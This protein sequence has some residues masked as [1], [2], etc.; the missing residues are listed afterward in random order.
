MKRAPGHEVVPEGHVEPFNHA[1]GK[2]TSMLNFRQ[3]RAKTRLHP[4]RKNQTSTSKQD[5]PTSD[6][7]KNLKRMNIVGIS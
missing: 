5:S 7:M 1:S 2:E 4:M 3:V 6:G